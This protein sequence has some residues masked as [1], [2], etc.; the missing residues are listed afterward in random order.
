MADVVARR[1]H[2][3]FTEITHPSGS[4]STTDDRM[5]RHDGFEYGYLLEG[6]LQVTLDDPRAPSR[7]PRVH[8]GPPESV[9]AGQPGYETP[10]DEGR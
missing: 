4:S 7:R 9:C 2:L 1:E 6:E 3:D 5:L 10:A 8:G